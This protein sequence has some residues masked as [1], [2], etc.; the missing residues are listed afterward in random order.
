[1]MVFN[2]KS[3]YYSTI[4]YRRP[5]NFLRPIMVKT[6]LIWWDSR[7]LYFEQ[8][9]ETVHD[10]FLRAIAYSRATIVNADVE[11]MIRKVLQQENCRSSNEQ[12]KPSQLY[13]RA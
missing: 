10:G 12:T 2:L 7:S 11:E 4:R 9:I 3:I 5:I 1:M 13:Y 6:K 8:R